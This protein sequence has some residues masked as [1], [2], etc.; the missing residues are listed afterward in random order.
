[1]CN[2][3]PIFFVI[4]FIIINKNIIFATEQKKEMVI[5]EL[6]FND[7]KQGIID[8]LYAEA[9]SSL[10][11]YA[12]RALGDKYAMMAEDCVQEAIVKAY[13]TRHTFSSPFQMKAFLFTCVHNQCIS[14]LRKTGT[15]D[16]YL[17][18]ISADAVE[19]EI[20]AA[21]IEQET[22]DLLHAAIDE[23][24][25][26]LRQVFELNFEQGLRNAEA[27]RLMSLSLNGFNKRKAKMI[28]LLRNKFHD[29]DTMLL[30][31]T[32]LMT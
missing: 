3:K 11:A 9:W 16:R 32:L 20:S 6:I 8:S 13:E 1:M 15:H 24:P 29:N 2:K 17:E 5:T 22:L 12:A 19:P 4:Y 18:N 7:F 25:E 10:M 30:F 26:E 28:S 14:L 23:L 21:L 31:I 27:A